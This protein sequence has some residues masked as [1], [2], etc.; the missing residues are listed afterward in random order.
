MKPGKN[1]G[2]R[3]AIL[4]TLGAAV[5]FGPAVFSGC[6]TNFTPSSKLDTLRVL[7]V[8]LDHPYVPDNSDNPD[9][10]DQWAKPADCPGDLDRC[11]VHFHM[12]LYD[13]YGVRTQGAE[14]KINILWIGG[15]FNPQADQYSLCAGPLIGVFQQAKDALTDA[16]NSGM[17]PTFPAG[18]PV[19]FGTDFTM[20]VP[21][22]VSSRP[23]PTFGPHYG[24]GYVF[25]LACAGRF[26]VVDPDPS[27]A[28]TFPIGCFDPDTKEPLGADSFVPGY[29]Q[30]YS[31]EDGRFN[32]NPQVGDD[33]NPDVDNQLVVTTMDDQPV[34]TDE[35]GMLVVP[36]CD[37]PP[38]ERYLPPS[39]TRQDAF[40]RCAPYKV[41]VNVPDDVAEVD[42][43]A[44]SESG[45]QLTETVWVDYLTD[46]GDLDGDIK[47]INDPQTGYLENHFGRWLPP[48]EPGIS[49]IW[50][51]VRDAR[52]GGTVV[53][54]QV[55]VE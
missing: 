12:E 1:R 25:F 17:K 32:T 44:K 30:I 49:T 53:K 22:I 51:V 36:T 43:D 55:K 39:C 31:F 18:L 27:A 8:T 16:L 45:Q 38:D 23:E 29:T 46:T 3:R 35:S 21:D 52:G 9:H 42:P 47:L 5:L 26:D 41:Y 37:V 20:V 11:T 15:C 48:A 19:G 14:R 6:A 33:A 40:D 54:R 28:G 7:A 4:G 13:G 10:P 2:I 24:I 34:P 50:A